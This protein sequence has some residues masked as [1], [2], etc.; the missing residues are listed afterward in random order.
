MVFI[1]INGK[2]DQEDSEQDTGAEH[3][4]P[5]QILA[6]RIADFPDAYNGVANEHDRATDE[7]ADKTY[8]E[9]EPV[10][11][12]APYRV[13][14]PSNENPDELEGVLKERSEDLTRPRW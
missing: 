2:I 12:K 13:E 1:H 8:A 7:Q 6:K 9:T 4:V 5:G 14:N 3:L 10:R 11:K